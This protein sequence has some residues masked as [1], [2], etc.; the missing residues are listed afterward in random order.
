MTGA[1]RDEL[2]YPKDLTVLAAFKEAEKSAV[3]A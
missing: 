1:L 2:N 3:L